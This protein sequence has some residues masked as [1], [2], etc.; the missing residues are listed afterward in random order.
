MTDH[1]FTKM[2]T[3]N[4]A[5][6]FE[7]ANDWPFFSDGDAIPIRFIGVWD[8]VGALGVPDDLE[9]FNFFDDKS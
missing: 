9:V 7:W 5:R 8:T 6:V 2:R 4:R 1:Q 3:Q